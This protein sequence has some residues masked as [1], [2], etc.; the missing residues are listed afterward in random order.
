M[1]GLIYF[2][3]AAT[4]YPKPPGVAYEVL[5]CINEY[6][7]NPGR[8][9]HPLALAS[10]EAIYSCR[11]ALAELFSVG[12]PENF[13]FTSN[14][15]HALNIAIKS[16]VRAGDRI[17]ISDIEHNAVLRPIHRLKT[18]GVCNYSLFDT[19]GDDLTILKGIEDQLKRGID[20]VISTHVSNV[21][22]RLLPINKI[23]KLCKSAGVYFIIDG[24]QSAGHLPIDLSALEF[25][26]FCAPGHKGLFGIQGSGFAFFRESAHGLSSVTEGGSGHDSSNLFMPE[27]LPERF[28]AGTLS[29]PAVAS[30]HAGISFLK[31]VGVK[32]IE[33]REARLA[34]ICREIISCFSCLRLFPASVSGGGYAEGGPISFACD[35]Y[36][37]EALAAILAEYG[38]CVR[39]GLHCAPLAHKKLGTAPDG[40]VRVSLGYFNTEAELD[41]FHAILKKILL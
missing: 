4:S 32:E 5:R 38:V 30:L 7:G 19:S 41:A 31:E 34:D 13:V 17:L 29:T 26:V 14:A 11:C 3:N 35:R 6:C 21:N 15:T 36:D 24:S 20:I 9:A 23:G 40:T 1:N 18:E 8:S 37:S 10:D 25:D 28:E 39:A 33:T 22:G 16:R 27:L 12:S 2:D